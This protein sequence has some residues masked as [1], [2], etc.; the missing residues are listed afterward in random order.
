M[1][2]GAEASS[3]EVVVLVPHPTSAEMLVCHPPVGEHGGRDGLPSVVLGPEPDT[4]DIVRAVGDL[5]GSPVTVLRAN[6]MSWHDN[7]DSA[8]MVVEVEPITSAVPEP[9]RWQHVEPSDVKGVSPRWAAESVGAW[10]VER[11]SGWSPL[12]PQWSRPGWLSRASSWMKHQ[13]LLAGYEHPEEPQIHWIWGVSVVLSAGS[14]SGTAYLKCS[15]DRFV[16]EPVVTRT[17]A[18]HSPTL[19]PQVFAIDAD[20]GWMLMRDMRG[21]PLGVQP[22]AGWGEGLVAL[23]Q[24]QQQW[25]GRTQELIDLGAE[26]RSLATLTQWVESTTDDTSLMSRLASGQRR[27]W[28]RSVPAMIEACRQLDTGGP[29]PTLVH[30]DFHP[31]NVFATQGGGVRVFDWTDASVSH[32]FVDLVTYI[33]RSDDVEV[34]QKL[35][36]L[37]LTR[38]DSQVS[39]AALTDLTRIALVVGSLHQAHTYSQLIPTVMPDDV[40]QL[41]DGDVGWLARA[42][43]FA[44]DGL[45]AQY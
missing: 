45:D 24:L 37:Y 7:F 36:R 31:W 10:L 44:D 35:V 2:D 27:A 34:R 42:M 38:W 41:R 32:P 8:S 17:L 16:T 14:A 23:Q 12:R 15:G 29:G 3:C 19:L 1:P 33:G 30:G 39:S 11:T 26:E 22:P 43:R 40:G 20:R 21:T 6:T 4:S 28:S 18:Q 5:L 25:L 9:F 13:M